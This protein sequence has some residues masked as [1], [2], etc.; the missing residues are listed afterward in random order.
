[1][2]GNK[3]AAIFRFVYGR[4]FTDTLENRIRM[5]KVVYA[6]NECNMSCG[7]YSFMW[8]ERGPFSSELSNDINH[9]K[10]EGSAY[11]LCF[12]AE[13]RKILSKIKSLFCNIPTG[14]DYDQLYWIE[15]LMS[16]HYIQNYILHHDKS[17]EVLSYLKKCKPYLSSDE[18]NTI[19]FSSV[20]Q[21]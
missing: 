17:C 11:R 12:D 15:T 10:T 14:V 6:M 2:N 21:F 16:I 7:D 18:S 9:M 20:Q 8:D 4:A 3:L 19:A 5:Q 1:M 13:G